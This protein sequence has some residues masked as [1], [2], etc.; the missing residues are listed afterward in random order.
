MILSP[1][2][3]LQKTFVY[4]GIRFQG[5]C[6]YRSV[7]YDSFIS[8]DCFMQIWLTLFCVMKRFR[9]AVCSTEISFVGCVSLIVDIRC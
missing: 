2:V 7:Q 6:C 5:M 1:D 4:Q 3:P 9:L 8:F